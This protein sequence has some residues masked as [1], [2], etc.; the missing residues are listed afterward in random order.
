VKAKQWFV[1]VGFVVV[2]VGFAFYVANRPMDFRVYH[3]GAR[4][5][6]DGTRPMYGPS[7]GLGW[8]M[9]YRYPPLFLLLF[10]PLAWLPLGASAAV[11]VLGK[12]IVLAAL[13]RMIS[14]RLPV[15]WLMSLLL[16]GAYVIEDF[17]YGNAQFFIFAL[18]VTG[19]VLVDESPIIAASSLALAIATKVWPLFFIPYL[20]VRRHIQVA[21]WTL[22]IASI[23]TLLP[24]FYFGFQGNWNL[25]QQWVRQE[26]TTQA[27]DEE[28]WFPSQSLRGVM[29]RYLTSIDYSRLPDSNYKNVNFQ[30]WNP[31]TVRTLWFVAAGTIYVVFLG[32]AYRREDPDDWTGEA[33]AFCLLTL[34]EPFTQKYA[35][36]VL[37]FPAIVADRALKAPHSRF[38]IY[39]SIILVL[40][41]PLIPGSSAQ[42]YMQV[43]GLDFAAT[44]MLAVG[45]TSCFCAPRGARRDDE[46]VW[47]APVPG[48]AFHS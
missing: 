13:I 41:Q 42:R 2:A 1:W 11:W 20:I 38:F 6:F 29:M 18:T 12:F 23:L 25:L 46:D 5:V 34:L 32:L 26:Y 9:H 16:A 10:A 31:K 45:L 22:V 15:G 30:S 8:P 28:I 19:L 7:S 39:A 3:F 14:R 44:A 21:V 33:V 40:I 48:K 17:R 47:K 35:L 37:L 24:S 43:I 4:G 36:V 27:G